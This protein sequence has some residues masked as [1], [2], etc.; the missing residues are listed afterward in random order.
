VYPPYFL[1]DNQQLIILS[2]FQYTHVDLS[3]FA[4]KQTKHFAVPRQN[5]LL[6]KK[7]KGKGKFTRPQSSWNHIIGVN[8]NKIMYE[9]TPLE[10]FLKY[11]RQVEFQYYLRAQVH[12]SVP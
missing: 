5:W 4:K 8:L 7:K 11:W 2:Y 12:L 3:K 10:K 1:P 9:M 6:L